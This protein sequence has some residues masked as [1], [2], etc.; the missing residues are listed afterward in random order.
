MERPDKTTMAVI[1]DVA[2]LD[3]VF[4]TYNE[5]EREE[6][7][8]KIQNMVP[9][10]VRVDGVHGSDAAHKACAD[11]STTD[12]FIIIDGDNMPDPEFFDQQLV[13]NNMNNNKDRKSVV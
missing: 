9:W 4:L 10:A 1:I 2:D 7:W 13:L 6:F 3:C 5:P 12:R 11:A 8:I